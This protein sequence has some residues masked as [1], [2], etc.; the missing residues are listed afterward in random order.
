MRRTAARAINRAFWAAE[1]ALPF[2]RARRCPCCQWSGVRFRV[3]AFVEYMRADAR[4]P[5]CGSMERHRA[6]SH[7]YPAFLE[8]L[9][10]SPRRAIHFAAEDSLKPIIKPLCGTYQTSWYPNKGS[11]D[12][13]LDLAKLDLPDES[14][15]LFIMNHVLNCVADDRPVVR[16][17]ARVLTPGG[18]VLATMTLKEGRTVEHP[19]QSNETYREYGIDELASAFSPFGVRTAYAAGTLDA[20]TRRIQGIP[21]PVTVLILTKN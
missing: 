16:E 18:I 17:M 12:L 13:N 2:A 21:E 6:L 7:F 9:P 8:S 4:C 15:D 20:E 11:S 3:I 1:R 14:C 19:R 10:G 5:G